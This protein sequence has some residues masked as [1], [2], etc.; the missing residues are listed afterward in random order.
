MMTNEVE[1]GLYVRKLPN[2][3]LVCCYGCRGRSI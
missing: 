3:M 1:I 2:F